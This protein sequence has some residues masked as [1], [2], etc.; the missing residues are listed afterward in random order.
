[1]KNVYD[2]MYNYKYKMKARWRQ[3]ENACAPTDMS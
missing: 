3:T 2:Y 1:M